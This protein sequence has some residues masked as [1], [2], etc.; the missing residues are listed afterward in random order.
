MCSTSPM[1]SLK[2]CNI[3]IASRNMGKLGVMARDS[4]IAPAASDALAEVV[5]TLPD[6][7]SPGQTKIVGEVQEHVRER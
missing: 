6:S 7:P 5:R 4:L 1:T 2:W 3:S